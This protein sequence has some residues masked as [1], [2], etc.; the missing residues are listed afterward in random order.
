MYDEITLSLLCGEAGF[1][2]TYRENFNTSRIKTWN[3]LELDIDDQNEEYMP[4]SLYIEAI[5]G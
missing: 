2:E 4:G 1:E 3:E 5:K